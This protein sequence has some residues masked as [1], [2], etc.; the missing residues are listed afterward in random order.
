MKIFVGQI[1][2]S[3]RLTTP[4]YPNAVEQFRFKIYYANIEL[5]IVAKHK[6]IWNE[7]A[8]FKSLSQKV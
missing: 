5:Y 2:T 4:K 3:A 1:W 8:F 6:V 7:I